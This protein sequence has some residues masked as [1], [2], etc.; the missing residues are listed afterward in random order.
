MY[1]P[2][3]ANIIYY[4]ISIKNTNRME[5]SFELIQIIELDPRNVDER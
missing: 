5:F 3:Y 4:F 2:S 1:L